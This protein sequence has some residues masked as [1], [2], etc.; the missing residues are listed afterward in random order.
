M[1][2]KL[3][4]PLHVRRDKPGTFFEHLP[5][6]GSERGLEL[7]V[8]GCAFGDELPIDAVQRNQCLDHAVDERDVSAHRTWKK[9]SISLVPNNA[10]LATHGTQ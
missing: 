9:S 5:G 10:L 2:V 7:F 8:A 4:K 3:G 6:L 1:T